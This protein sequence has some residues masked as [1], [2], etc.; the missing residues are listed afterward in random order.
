VGD[1]NY[2]QSTEQGVILNFFKGSIGK[3]LDIGAYDGMTLSNT[4]A[5]AELGWS[6]V[7]IEP[8]LI[9][10]SRCKGLYRNNNKVRVIDVAI[11]EKDERAVFYDTPGDFYGS[12]MKG[13]AERYGKTSELDIVDCWSC[14]TLFK[15]T[16]YDFDFISLD[17]EGNN[18]DVLTSIP[19]GDLK[20]LRLLCI[21]SDGRWKDIIDYLAPY[22]FKEL[23]RT[24]ENI[25][26]CR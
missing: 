24:P 4:Y 17:V 15:E 6:G 22:D 11:G 10:C 23:H 18:F 12:M 9:N 13:N 5:L 20:Q 25:I 19:I 16:G 8:S 2:S 26:M 3:F 7:C 14:S 21:E 1:V